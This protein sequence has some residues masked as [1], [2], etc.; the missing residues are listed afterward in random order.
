MA[1]QS[2]LNGDSFLCFL[3]PLVFDSLS[4]RSRLSVNTHSFRIANFKKTNG[5]NNLFRI[6][7]NLI[8]FMDV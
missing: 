2:K 1:P 4:I 8:H 3:P 7:S 5:L 6:L